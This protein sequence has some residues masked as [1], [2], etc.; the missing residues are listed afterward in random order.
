MSSGS[1]GGRGAKRQAGPA[2]AEGDK[3]AGKP[4]GEPAAKPHAKLTD[5]DVLSALGTDSTPPG[6][7]RPQAEQKAKQQAKS[8]AAADFQAAKHQQALV[9]EARRM[10]SEMAAPEHEFPFLTKY[11]GLTKVIV[12]LLTVGILLSSL[13]TVLP[14]TFVLAATALSA[15]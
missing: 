13:A 7:A 3:S 1:S 4:T 10:R 6:A 11:A 12:I 5:D 2:A 15:S 8:V 14:A 9:A